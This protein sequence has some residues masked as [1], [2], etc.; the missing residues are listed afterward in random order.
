MSVAF[1]DTGRRA[2]N[3]ARR[4]FSPEGFLQ[5][6]GLTGLRALAALLVVGFHLMACVRVERQVLLGFLDVT[7]LITIGWVGVDVFFVLSGFLITIHLAE[8]LGRGGLR[9]TYAG[10][11]R[12]R[13]LRVVPAY[14]AQIAILLSMAYY[15]TRE[16]PTWVGIIPMHMAFLQNF[17]PD[18]FS[19]I[20]GVYW[21]LPV[22][23]SFYL[24][25]PFVLLAAW[26]R[27]L[28]SRR[29]ARRA[30]AV[31]AVGIAISMAW[32]A[33]A[34]A[35]YGPSGV[36]TIFWAS[37]AFLPGGAEQF[38][39]GM[40]AAMAFAASGAPDATHDPAWART[41]D[42]LV[43]AGLL[44]LAASMY[45]LDALVERY[46]SASIVFYAW[47]SLVSLP[48]GLLVAGVAMRGRL[49]RA[50]FE[51]APVMWLGTVSYSLYLWQPA[52]VSHVS[53]AV[54]SK[55]WSYWA[56]AAVALPA[57][58]LAAAASYYLV[59]R[60]FLRMKRRPACAPRTLQ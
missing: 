4:F 3:E 26:P 44:G 21:S 33:W 16:W 31:A 29:L 23:F 14:W 13:V 30:I 57:F 9:E 52:L 37:A 58:V 5:R 2:A 49:A 45:A 38:A 12:D 8:R 47:H 25:A 32:R 53:E 20:N 22:E 11:L 43:L 59:E 27:G 7:P 6:P 50:I 54:G 35:A 15:L 17:S 42:R 51:N 41:S 24:V 55:T 18:A 48:V 39:V 60:P 19:A 36:A 28:D 34:V 10:Y 46:W 1:E 40:A 56:F